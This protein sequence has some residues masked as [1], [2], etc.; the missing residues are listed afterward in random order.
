MRRCHELCRLTLCLVGE[1][2]NLGDA[3]L[4]DELGAL[5]AREE[6]HVDA[7]AL[8][9]RVCAMM[10]ARVVVMTRVEWLHKSLIMGVHM[11]VIMSVIARVIVRNSMHDYGAGYES[12]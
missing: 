8:E 12:A 9:R 11:H 7:A 6:G 4:D 1:E 10:S 5:V 3:A 2:D